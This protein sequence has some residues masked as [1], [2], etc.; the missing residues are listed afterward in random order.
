MRTR[1]VDKWPLLIC[2]PMLRR[3][4]PTSVAVFVATKAPCTVELVL[5]RINGTTD[6]EQSSPQPTRAIGSLLHV[7]VC[8]LMLPD[9]KRLDPGVVYA[10][11]L[12]MTQTDPPG[13]PRQLKDQ[14]GL[15][16]GAVP[17]GYKAGQLPT[18]S[19]PPALPR[20]NIVHGSC[21]KPHGGGPDA[22][23]IVDELIARAHND[24]AIANGTEDALRRPH[25]LL[26][27]GDQIYADDV[28]VVLLPMLIAAGGLLIEKAVEEHFGGTITMTDNKVKPGWSRQSYLEENSK[29]S[30]EYAENHLMYFAEFCAMY[31]MCWSDEIW[32]RN[33]K[34]LPTV[35]PLDLNQAYDPKLPTDKRPP[36]VK[37]RQGLFCDPLKEAR[38]V[39]I[40]HHLEVLEFASTVRRIRRVLANVPTLMMFDDHEVSDDWN[41]DKNWNDAS[42]SDPALHRIVR[43]GLLAAAVF[44]AWGN[45]PSQFLAGAGKDVLDVVT[46]PAGQTHSPISGNPA[47]A[48]VLLDI[49]PGPSPAPAVR[50]NWDWTLDC[51]EHR[52]IA[53]DTR[54]QRDFTS[55]DKSEEAGLLTSSE[56]KRQ[57]SDQKPAAGSPQLCFVLSPAPVIGHPLVE[58]ILQPALAFIEGG[59]AADSEAWGL[60]RPRFEELLQQLAAFGRVVL[61]SGDVHYAYTNQ[62]AY[63]G[64]SPQ[65]PARI[66]QLCSS[67]A[68][69]ADGMTRLIQNAGYLKMISRNWF[70][71][72]KPFDDTGKARLRAG[73][74]AG[75]EARPSDLATRRLYCDFTLH[76]RL[77]TPAVVPDGPWFSPQA[78]AEINGH[79]VSVLSGNWSYKVTFVRDARKPSVR[80]T[81]ALIPPVSSIPPAVRCFVETLGVSVVGEPNIGQVTLRTVN[82]VLQ[83]VHRIHWLATGV[84]LSDSVLTYTEHIAPLGPPTPVERPQAFQ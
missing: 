52:V 4:T 23:A 40:A 69:N 55:P 56:L 50:L 82:G 70:G 33:D 76:D 21:R 11:D 53:L 75:T 80:V 12:R 31:V 72:S 42:R 8:E 27:T 81:D 14:D 32:P 43:N 36:S 77:A 28:A 65:S 7:A 60:N 45:V 39:A 63:F 1:P 83:V 54:T 46:V 24:P 49:A 58:E 68:K 18:F 44:Q 19:L 74:Q 84:Q 13:P 30:S 48:D 26:L 41:I 78:L 22:L 10:Y 20:L 3:V 71:F 15:L 6:P 57:L 62:T 25:Q 16:S 34:G 73:L 67:S 35:T 2:G 37:K 47:A 51:L 29:L 61:L 66:V 5:S 38:I 64:A 59:R 9:D 17:L 79:L